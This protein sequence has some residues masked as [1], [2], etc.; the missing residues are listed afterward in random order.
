MLP[1]F[2]V[3]AAAV[4]AGKLIYDAVTDDNSSTSSSSGPKKAEPEQERAKQRVAE[5]ARLTKEALDDIRR[6]TQILLEVHSQI[7]FGNTKTTLRLDDLHKVAAMEPS[8]KGLKILEPL[9]IGL[10]YTSRH[11]TEAR[12]IEQLKAEHAEL[13]KLIRSR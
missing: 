2:A 10:N 1:V 6:E 13:Q 11:K 8:V 3:I 5:R 4:A 9:T 7:V 12:Q